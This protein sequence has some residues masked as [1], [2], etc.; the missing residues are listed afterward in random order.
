VEVGGT[1]R[2]QA[3]QVF[4]KLLTGLEAECDS[5]FVSFDVDS[6]ASKWMPGVS[7][8]SVVGGL[9]GE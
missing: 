6:I 1:W 9:S 7:S 8:P 4:A 5:I 3:G 2:T